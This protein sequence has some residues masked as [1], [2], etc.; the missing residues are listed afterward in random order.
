MLLRDLKPSFLILD[1]KAEFSRTDEIA[2]ADGIVF[3]C[4]KCYAERGGE[5][6]THSI[7]CWQPH[8]SKEIDPGPGRWKFSGTGYDDLTL[9]ASSSSILLLSGCRAHFFIRDGKIV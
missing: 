6:G 1:S 3:L 2:K 8:V 4:P 9:T 5:V 7:I